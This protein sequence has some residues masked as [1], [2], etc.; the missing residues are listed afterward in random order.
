[1]RFLP[2]TALKIRV[3]IL[4]FLVVRSIKGSLEQDNCQRFSLFYELRHGADW[5]ATPM[6]RLAAFRRN[7]RARAFLRNAAKRGMGCG[8][9]FGLGEP[10]AL[11]RNSPSRCSTAGWSAV[12]CTAC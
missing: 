11:V 1:M 2:W 8:R 10:T 6:P 5:C 7:A 3:L 12:Y 9:Q 4:F